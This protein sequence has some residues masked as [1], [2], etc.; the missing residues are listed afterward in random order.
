[1]EK[2]FKDSRAE[3]VLEAEELALGFAKWLHLSFQGGQ[4]AEI[5]FYHLSITGMMVCKEELMKKSHNIQLQ[6][7]FTTF[8]QEFGS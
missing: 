8:S 6:G 1:M 2:F 4:G 7:L 5:L 3:K